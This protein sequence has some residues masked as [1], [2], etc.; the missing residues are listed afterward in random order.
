VGTATANGMADRS[1]I[2]GTD[3]RFS[4][5]H[6]IQAGSGDHRTSAPIGTGGC[7]P[8]SGKAPHVCICRDQE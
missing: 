4:L 8:M 7:F 5:P 2:P 6:S 1:S 3:M